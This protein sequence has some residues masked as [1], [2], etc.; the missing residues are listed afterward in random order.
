[1]K[2][3]FFPVI[4]ALE[5]RIAPATV[6]STYTDADGDK[7]TITATSPASAAALADA[8]EA[9][10]S[11]A[12]GSSGLQLTSLN[13]SDPAFN[14]GSVS[15]VATKAGNGDGFAAVGQIITG[16]Q[17]L[18]KI[19]VDG[20]LGKFDAS[21]SMGKL[22]VQSL[23]RYGTTTGAT[24]LFSGV[25]LDMGALIVKGDVVDVIISSGDGTIGTLKIGGSLIGGSAGGSGSI[26]VA[27]INFL[28]IGG[29]IEAGTGN[30]SGEITS[31]LGI[32]VFSVKGSIIG[33][34]DGGADTGSQIR[35]GGDVGVF[36]VGGDIAATGQAGYATAQVF[37]TGTIALAKI[38]GSLIGRDSS[39]QGAIA[40]QDGIGKITVLGNLVGNSSTAASI[41][42]SEGKIG[43][44]QI[45]GSMFGGNLTA[46]SYGTVTIGG[47]LLGRNA[48][49]GRII[50]TT[51]ATITSIT[52][53]GSVIGGEQV[54]SGLI[55]T[56]AGGTITSLVIGG[57]LRTTMAGT[58]A[59]NAGTITNALIGGSIFASDLVNTPI[60]QISTSGSLG[61][62][63]V[64][65]SLVGNDQ[66]DV[67]I[68]LGVS[69]LAKVIV[70]GR[71]ENALL[72]AGAN[73]SIA[74][75]SVGGDWI[76]SRVAIGTTAGGDNLLGTNDD[77]LLPG[78]SSIRAVIIKGQ[79]LGT[80]E[81]GDS[82][83]IVART[84]SALTIGGVSYAFGTGAQNFSISVTGDFVVRDVA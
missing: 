17:V 39:N 70:K 32:D 68:G 28:T 64:I 71:V 7:V 51:D 12:L 37:S 38:G 53:G 34:K 61:T 48:A 24:D 72:F 15:I 45:K 84:I 58:G 26:S 3:A 2:K 9:A 74:K 1:M 20:D 21:Q 83:Q 41:T 46:E 79:A 44:L 18:T 65:G 40:A 27:A 6:F 33:K 76:A 78:T 43:S 22:V 11:F 62:L 52:I 5:S 35:I 69:E 8:L 10:G 73:S 50:S 81:A 75:I 23:G 67:S 30:N 80:P 13:L 31:S 56:A 47:D 66:N 49:T 60:T 42:S 14:N 25:N 16:N 82:Y 59:V 29:N 57:D 19:K 36:T 63:R 54:N 77:V 4:E 55:Q